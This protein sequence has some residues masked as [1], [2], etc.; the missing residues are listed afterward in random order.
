MW[1]QTCQR[2]T[3]CEHE[4]RRQGDAPASQEIAGTPHELGESQ[5][6]HSALQHQPSERNQLCQYLI[7][8]L[9]SRTKRWYIPVV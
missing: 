8:D 4:G 2:R 6:T 3:P 9:A 5:G 7:L 1:R